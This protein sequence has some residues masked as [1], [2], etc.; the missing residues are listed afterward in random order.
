TR[1]PLV[2]LVGVP[3]ALALL[4]PALLTH[5]GSCARPS[6]ARFRLARPA[7][8]ALLAHLVSV[9]AAQNSHRAAPPSSRYNNSVI[10]QC[11]LDRSSDGDSLFAPYLLSWRSTSA[12]S[13]FP[14]ATPSPAP[15]LPWSFLIFVRI[16]ACV[17]IALRIAASSTSES[18][19]AHP[20]S[21]IT[22]TFSDS[23]CTSEERP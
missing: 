20:P 2:V 23:T 6:C 19:H 7:T 1:G 21:P 12:V 22:S 5:R 10:M 17:R 11:D 14:Q 8:G 13:Q 18:S 9:A 16:P 3:P 15:L 4:P